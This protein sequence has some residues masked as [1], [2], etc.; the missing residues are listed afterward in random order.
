MQEEN[1]K[2]L[3]TE[4]TVPNVRVYGGPKQNVLL[5]KTECADSRETIDSTENTMYSC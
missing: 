5:L 4:C 3:E 1:C 2:M